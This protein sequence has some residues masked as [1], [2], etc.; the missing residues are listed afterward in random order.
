MNPGPALLVY[1]YW[2]VVGGVLSGR[3][4]ALSWPLLLIFGQDFVN[5][6]ASVERQMGDGFDL[7]VCDLLPFEDYIR[8][9][10][11]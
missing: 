11:D 2:F 4:T 3:Q 8:P 10:P 6:V 9:C 5:Q 7:G 1:P